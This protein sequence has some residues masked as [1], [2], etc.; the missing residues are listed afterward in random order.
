[1]FVRLNIW[2]CVCHGCTFLSK[3]F[4]T[5]EKHSVIIFPSNSVS[6]QK[7]TSLTILHFARINWKFWFEIQDTPSFFN[8]LWISSCY[9]N[10]TLFW[11]WSFDTVI[12][13]IKA[14]LKIILSTLD[15]YQ[16]L[17]KSLSVF[18]FFEKH[19]NLITAINSYYRH[20]TFWQSSCY[21]S[22]NCQLN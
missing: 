9:P 7:Y 10:V 20:D 17:C 12:S 3:N 2:E 4:F 6:K 8:F 13:N 14:Y 18:D 15:F 22:E 19:S 1:M 11:R 21:D 5:E 16:I